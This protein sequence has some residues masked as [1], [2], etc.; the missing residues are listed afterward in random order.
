MRAAYVG[1]DVSYLWLIGTMKS[2]AFVIYHAA[3]MTS[4]YTFVIAVKINGDASA[5]NGAL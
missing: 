5:I 4:I 1:F 3:N 2:I